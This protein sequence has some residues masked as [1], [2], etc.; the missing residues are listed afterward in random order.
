MVARNVVDSP[1]AIATQP[2]SGALDERRKVNP[3]G[4]IWLM[5]P[6]ALPF[7]GLYAWQSRPQL[8]LGTELIYAAQTTSSLVD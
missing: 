3:V 4:T 7:H 6:H 5:R 1:M 2:P 8:P